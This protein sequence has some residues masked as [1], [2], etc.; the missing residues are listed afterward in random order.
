[1]GHEPVVGVTIHLRDPLLVEVERGL[2][3]PLQRY[4][5][6]PVILPRLTPPSQIERILDVVDAV[7]VSGGADVDP[8]HYGEERHELTQPIEAEMD[9]FEI[10]LTRAALDRGVPVLGLCRGAQVLAVADGGALTQ[11]VE[12]LHEGAHRHWHD[13]KGLATLPPGEHWHEV[14]VEPG[15]LV[16]RWLAGGRPRVN[17]FH[18]Q[19]VSD[20]GRRHTVTARTRD[21]VVEAIERVDGRGFAVGLQWH[22]EL[23]WQ[24]DERFLRPFEALVEAARAY[25]RAG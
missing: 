1:M 15:S 5:A 10:G 17:S 23:Q 25:A 21:G 13:W 4:G 24:H 7:Q 19:S 16:E 20:P 6:L 22:N 12:T 14:L 18:H 2:R 9:A 8:A 3:E 11:D